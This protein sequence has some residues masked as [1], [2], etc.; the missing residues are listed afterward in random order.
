MYPAFRP[1]IYF[2]GGLMF[3]ITTAHAMGGAPQG[4]ADPTGG[5]ASFLPLLAMIAVF[6]F[7]LIRPQQKRAKQHRE[8]VENLKRGD[9]V[10]TNGGIYGRIIETD[11]E[12]VVLDLGDSKIKILRSAISAVPSATSAPAEKKSKKGSDKTIQ[13]DDKE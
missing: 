1:V 13:T 2:S 6:Y 12:T 4:G 11:K 9:E 8:M 10:I 5:F 7:L 3:W